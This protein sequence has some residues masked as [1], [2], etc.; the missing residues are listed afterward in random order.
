V[1]VCVA[2]LWHLGTVTAACLASG[3]HQVAAYDHNQHVVEGLRRGKAPLFEP[4]LDDLISHELGTGRLR[5]TD[6]PA[7]AL[8]DAV[9]LWLT[10]DTPVDEDDHGDVEA[11]VAGATTLFRHLPDGALVIVSSQVTVGTTRRLE[12]AFAAEAGGRRVS[13]AYSPENIRLGQAIKVFTQPDRVVAGIRHPDDRERISALLR[14]FTDRIE[15]MSVESAE[16]TKHALNAFLALSVTFIN[17]IAA[18]CEGVGADASEVA[19]G[20][21]SDVR[22]GPRAYLSPGGPF[23][24]GTLA[25]DVGF[26]AALGEQ[27]GLPTA[28]IPAVRVSND[29]HAAWPR[30]H[31]VQRLGDLRDKRVAVWGLTYK[32]GTS[33]LRRSHVLELCAW[34]RQQGAIVQAHDPAVL[35]L[36]GELAGEMVIASTPLDAARDADALV[37]ATAWPEFRSVD[38]AAVADAM[39]GTLVLD[40][41]GF[42]AGS[43]GEHPAFR[44]VRV[45]Q[46]P[47]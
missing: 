33:T 9:I 38:P 6:D 18:I 3:G 44:Y 1:K 4:G 2:G 26:L 30:R 41:N 20:L 23:A 10:A 5:P 27:R 7:E 22:I 11:V 45:G 35:E 19:R 43:L 12:A 34:L 31:L 21:K 29:A 42:L 46:H 8:A 39:A 28:V 16:M 47:S 17:E 32:P 40:A 25:R 24:G 36:P 13:F 15:W 37:V 14:P